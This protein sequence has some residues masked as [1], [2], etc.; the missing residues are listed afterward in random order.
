MAVRPQHCFYCGEDLGDYDNHGEPDACGKQE[1]QRE[2]RN[3]YRQE[4]E[5]AQYRAEQDD[6]DRYR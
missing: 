6:F 3:A 4:R 1:C 2:L 5:E